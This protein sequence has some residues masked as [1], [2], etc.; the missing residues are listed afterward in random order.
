MRPPLEGRTGGLGE[1][2]GDLQLGVALDELVAIDERR[3]VRL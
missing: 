2:P 1:G 3:Q